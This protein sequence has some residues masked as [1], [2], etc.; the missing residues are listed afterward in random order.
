MLVKDWLKL[1]YS[2][3]KKANSWKLLKSIRI[4]KWTPKV[5]EWPLQA[6]LQIRW[7]ISLVFVFV[8]DFKP[9]SIN[10]FAEKISEYLVES[11]SWQR[12]QIVRITGQPPLLFCF[13]S[14]LGFF[15]VVEF[16]VPLNLQVGLTCE[17]NSLIE[18]SN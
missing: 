1:N 17:H 6:E 4:F 3:T 10:F 8:D 11:L 14:W 12:L 2:S 7:I 5:K 13:I 18:Y 9:P 16:M 15:V